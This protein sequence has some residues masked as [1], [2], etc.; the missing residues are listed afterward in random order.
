MDDIPFLT[1]LDRTR[2]SLEFDHAPV[3]RGWK[4]DFARAR[5]A[6]TRRLQEDLAAAHAAGH[7]DTEYA[8]M[9]KLRNRDA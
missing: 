1:Q 7:Q 5:K 9:Q 6:V 8:L 2:T 3:V 4:G